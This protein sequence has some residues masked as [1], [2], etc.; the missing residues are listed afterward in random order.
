[1]AGGCES[2]IIILAMDEGPKR[3]LVI[4]AGIL[5]ARH[6]KTTED[7]FDARDSPDT[8]SCESADSLLLDQEGL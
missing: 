3:V 2:N 4:V 5:V 1:M 6:L 8:F 7:L